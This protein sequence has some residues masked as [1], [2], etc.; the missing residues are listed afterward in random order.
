MLFEITIDDIRGSITDP[1][2]LTLIPTL[3]GYQQRIA[4]QAFGSLHNIH[5]INAAWGQFLKG[6]KTHP[7][8][9][10]IG[11]GSLLYYPNATASLALAGPGGFYDWLRMQTPEDLV[12]LQ[13]QASLRHLYEITPLLI[14]FDIAND[15]EQLALIAQEFLDLDYN[16]PTRWLS[17]FF[18]G[19][20]YCFMEV[21]LI[22]IH[23]TP[24]LQ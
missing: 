12:E 1:A 2:Y 4:E 20:Q 11:D 17:K 24:L 15:P 19:L 7:Q 10:S 23:V 21:Y 5:N 16:A 8:D 14:E 3:H 9:I 18:N 22:K 6:I 13:E